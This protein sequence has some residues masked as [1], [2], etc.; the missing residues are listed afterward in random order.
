LEANQ[1]DPY[2]IELRARFLRDRCARL[3]AELREIDE[4][5][6]AAS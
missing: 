2:E 3:L 4:E 6:E 5:E 1:S